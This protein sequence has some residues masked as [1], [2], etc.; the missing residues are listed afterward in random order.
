[1]LLKI[2]NIAD[3]ERFLKLGVNALFWNNHIKL[4]FSLRLQLQNELFGK[5]Q[6]G[7]GNVLKSNDRYYHYCFDH[8]LLACENCGKSLYCKKNI[9]QAYSATYVSHIISRSN[10]PEMAHDPRN[11]NIL[12]GE[13]HHKWESPNNDEM[14][15]YYDN[16]VVIEELKKEYLAK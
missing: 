15:I 12:C 10:A 9:D 2:D 8:S 11:H 3:Y 13:C 1:M 5:S 6:L 4:E 7:N 14:I 16:L